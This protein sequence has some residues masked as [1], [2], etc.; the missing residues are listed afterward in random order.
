MVPR[1]AALRSGLDFGQLR[2]E[3]RLALL[4]GLGNVILGDPELFGYERG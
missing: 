3:I 1:L 4:H 2:Q